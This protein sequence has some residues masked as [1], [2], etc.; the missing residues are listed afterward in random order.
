MINQ[1]CG[2]P[3]SDVSWF[4]FAPVTI[5]ISTT[6]H[7]YWSYVNQR[8]L[9]IVWGPHIVDLISIVAMPEI[10]NMQLKVHF[11]RA[12]R[13]ALPDIAPFDDPGQLGMTRLV[14]QLQQFD[15]QLLTII[16]RDCKCLF[17]LT[18][19]NH[20]LT[21]YPPLIQHG[22]EKMQ[23]YWWFTLWAVYYTKKNGGLW[24]FY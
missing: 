20:L 2:P 16:S 18:M 19:F 22:H 6:N 5:D 10:E 12:K 11:P 3:P 9:A 23:I 8:N 14:R 7:S 15:I 24:L 21:T 17:C 13:L 4:R 1:Q